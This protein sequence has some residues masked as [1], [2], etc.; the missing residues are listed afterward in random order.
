[1]TPEQD[2]EIRHY[3]KGKTQ[4]GEPWDTAEL[5]AMLKDML[6]PPTDEVDEQEDD[7]VTEERAE[8]ERASFSV[9]E[10]MD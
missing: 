5:R 1:M 8:M 4:R 10:E 6:E 3:I 7:T 9:E 2:A